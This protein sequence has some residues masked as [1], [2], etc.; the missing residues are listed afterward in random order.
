M[1]REIKVLIIDNDDQRRHDLQVIH[2]FLGDTVVTATSSDWA[3]RA[4]E[5][6]NESREVVAVLVGGVESTFTLETLLADLI[7]WDAG[8]P[9]LLLVSPWPPS[10]S[11]GRSPA[12]RA[13][14]CLAP[15]RCTPLRRAALCSSVPRRRCGLTDDAALVLADALRV[16]RSPARLDQ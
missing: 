1:R 13:G 2:E 11:D 3:Q 15:L 4:A 12:R 5:G 8:V 14:P 6:F 10:A 7:A 16:N 9:V